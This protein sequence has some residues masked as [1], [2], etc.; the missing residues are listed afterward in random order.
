MNSRRM[1]PMNKQQI[2]AKYAKLAAKKLYG[3]DDLKVEFPFYL[4]SGFKVYS[5]ECSYRRDKTIRFNGVIFKEDELDNM[6]WY[7]ILHELSHIKFLGHAKEFWE[8]L[9][10][11]FEKTEE[12]RER[13]YEESGLDGDS[14]Q[15]MDFLTYSDDSVP[16]DTEDIEIDY[17]NLDYEDIFFSWYN[18][19][20]DS[21]D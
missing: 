20:E 4:T 21:E 10:N 16:P 14:Y 7:L 17:E 19:F 18:L 5:G 12:L 1:N 9:V 8:E 3:I 2:M 15:D 11:N 13:F 6:A